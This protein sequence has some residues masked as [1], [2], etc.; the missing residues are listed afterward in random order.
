MLVEQDWKVVVDKNE[1]AMKLAYRRYYKLLHKIPAYQSLS[2]PA[3]NVIRN[4]FY[5]GYCE[6]ADIPFRPHEI[7]TY[8]M[9]T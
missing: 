1:H 8:E 6:G 5:Y 7:G 2:K 4:M 9:F 3:K